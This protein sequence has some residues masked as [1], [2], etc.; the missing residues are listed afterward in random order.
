MPRKPVKLA[1]GVRREGRSLWSR[2]AVRGVS[3]RGERRKTDSRVEWRAWSASKSKVAAALLR[4]S[5]NPSDLLPETG[6]TCL[7]LGASY[8]STVSHIHDQACG[9]GNHHGGQVVAV[10]ISPR[11]MREL[12]TLAAS[13]PG[14]VTVLGDARIP[15]QIAP[16]M[17]GKADWI[18]QDLSIADQAQTFVRLSA[19][20]LR[21]GGTGLLSLKAASERASQGDDDSRFAN[22][23]RILEDSDLE[24]VERIELKGLEDQ[25]VVFHIRG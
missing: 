22:A 23:E 1:W 7:Y 9:S 2:N 6:S 4:T 11:A 3:V 19:A 20:F 17:R 24:L 25:H 8:G 10:E 13:R 5:N 18:H 16:F 12:S 21:K 14:L 15:S